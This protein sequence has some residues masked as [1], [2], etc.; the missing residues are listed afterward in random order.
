MHASTKI[1]N[2]K[3]SP[4]QKTTIGFYAAR[5]GKV[6]GKG[7]GE[8]ESYYDKRITCSKNWTGARY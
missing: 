6:K 2:V 1:K 3:S 4:M 7:K 5:R 8:G